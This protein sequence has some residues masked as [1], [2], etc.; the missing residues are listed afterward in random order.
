MHVSG[1]KFEVDA[2]IPSPVLTDENG[3]YAGVDDTARRV[4]NA[5]ILNKEGTYEPIDLNRAYTIAGFN[6]HLMDGGGQGI[7]NGA[8]IIA[9]DMGQDIEI[10]SL[11]VQQYLKG[12]IDRRYANTE[13][14]IRIT[15]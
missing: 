12:K 10:L 15:P 5:Q 4:S 14:R 9:S 3:L 7:L 8:N 6:Y 1:L 11:Y 2:S 13:G